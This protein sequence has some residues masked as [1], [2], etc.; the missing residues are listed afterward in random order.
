MKVVDEEKEK[1]L[2][3]IDDYLKR[4]IDSETKDDW[5]KRSEIKIR[6]VKPKINDIKK[7]ISKLSIC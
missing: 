4:E 6:K 5:I 1:K 7:E 3:M 2:N